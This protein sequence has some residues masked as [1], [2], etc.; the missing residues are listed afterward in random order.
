M[1]VSENLRFE[2]DRYVKSL[3]ADPEYDPL[4]WWKANSI[5]YPFLAKFT[6]KYLSICPTSC[7]RKGSLALQVKLYPFLLN[8]EKVN[9]LVFLA[10]SMK[11]Q[12]GLLYYI[13]MCS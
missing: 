13:I 10:K 12:L 3:M 8:P 7:L 11:Q 6:K 5:H 2:I 4:G 9:M 1:T